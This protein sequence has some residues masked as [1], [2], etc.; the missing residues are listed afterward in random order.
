MSEQPDKET[1]LQWAQAQ[2]DA[3]RLQQD[4]NNIERRRQSIA[5][6]VIESAQH[7]AQE[8]RLFLH[9]LRQAREAQVKQA[10]W[11]D[12]V[13]E[14]I[15]NRI[16]R[17]E[18]NQVLMLTENNPQKRTE[19]S[20]GLE[21]ELATRQELKKR[22]RNLSKLQEQ[23]AEYGNVDTPLKLMNAIEAEQERIA[24]LEEKLS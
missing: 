6:Q 4:A 21:R 14:D 7:L 8:V 3:N 13:F 2:L 12:R 1:L 19:A 20:Q 16:E 23:A 18:R 17:L 22:Y 15:A 10:I 9:E 11:Q 5:L 24:E